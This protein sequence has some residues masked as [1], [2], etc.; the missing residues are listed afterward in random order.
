MVPMPPE[1]ESKNILGLLPDNFNKSK[2]SITYG[3]V[4]SPLLKEIQNLGRNQCLGK[5]GWP[6]IE[7]I[8]AWMITAETATFMKIGGLGMIASELP[9]AFNETYTDEKMTV[10]TPLY[11]GDTKKKK[12]AFDKD[13]YLGSESENIKL[14]KLKSIDVVFAGKKGTLINH[15]VQIFTGEL[16][17]VRYIFLDN[18]RFF[19]INPHKN[20]KP[21]QQ[22]CYVLNEDGVDEVE[23]FAFFSKAVYVL[24]KGI[25]EGKIKDIGKPNI[26]VANDWHSGALS[27]LTKYLTTAQNFTGEMTADLAEEI[28]AVPVIHIAH[29]LGYQGWD[30]N[31]TSKILNSLYENVASLVF[32]N[33]RAIKNTNPRTTN[34]LIVY[35]CYNQASCNFHLADRVVTVSKNYLEEVSKN[36]KFG[37]DFRDILKIRKDHRNFFGI[38]NGYDKDLISPNEEKIKHI[39]EYFGDTDFRV[40]SEKDAAT[41]NHNKNEFVKL[42]SKIA[43][44]LEYK[45]K[46]IPLI[47]IYKFSDLSKKVKHAENVAIFSATSRLVEQ[48]GYDIAAEAIIKVIDGA[49]KIDDLPIFILGGAGEDA[50]FEILRKLKDKVMKINPKIGER[51]FVFHGYRDQFAYVIQLASDFYMMPSRFEPCG[52]TQMEALAKGALPIVTSTG[53]LVDTIDEN[54]DGFKTEVFFVDKTRVFGSNL[55]AQ[56]LKNNTNAYAE[57]LLKALNT[58]Y[59]DKKKIE[60]MKVNAMHKDFSWDVEKGALSKY[61]QLFKTG[62]I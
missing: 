20:N 53:G 46:V 57:T 52:L 27:G 55:T 50:Q 14:T 8:D 12:A 28:K 32:K 25:C 24:L 49:P 10:V 13:V 54:I 19:S 30:Y 58:F 44:D 42:I 60:E 36:L 40:Y 39:N 23:R 7:K 62:H 41:K 34:T 37:Y 3:I 4:N 2:F 5:C 9:E 47:D 15:K 56:R 31:N 38:V 11:L 16:K 61:Y 1:L 59:E 18:D 33:A 35:D 26:L 43:K 6:H 45:Q 51:V 48:K 21:S 22:G 29:H 17:G